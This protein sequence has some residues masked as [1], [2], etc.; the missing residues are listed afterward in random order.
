M[1]HQQA[2]FRFL[3]ATDTVT[4]SRYLLEAGGKQVLVDC[5]LF[6]GCSGAVSAW[7]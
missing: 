5:R 1:K 6:P 7:K 4:G 3:G 2:T